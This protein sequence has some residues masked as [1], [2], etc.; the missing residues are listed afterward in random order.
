MA[1]YDIF[2]VKYRKSIKNVYCQNILRINVKIDLAEPLIMGI[3][4]GYRR[5]DSSP[6]KGIDT[7]RFYLLRLSLL[8][9][10]DNSSTKGIDTSYT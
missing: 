10:N 5:N 3:R 7:L 9:R 8:R 6:T 4:R 2:G 1:K